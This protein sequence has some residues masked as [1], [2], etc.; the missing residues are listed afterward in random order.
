MSQNRHLSALKIRTTFFDFGTEHAQRLC[1]GTI[2]YSSAMFRANRTELT[3][4]VTA[5]RTSN[6]SATG[7]RTSSVEETLDANPPQ[8]ADAIAATNNSARRYAAAALA[9]ATAVA[10]TKTVAQTAAPQPLAATDPMKQA[11][12]DA[13]TGSYANVLTNNL[14]R[15]TPFN[16]APVGIQWTNLSNGRSDGA[17]RAV[18]NVDKQGGQEL[19]TLL[20]GTLVDSPFSTFGTQ[21]KDQ[22]IRMPNGQMIDA[23]VLANSLNAARTAKDPFSATQNVLDTYRAEAASYNL[24]NSTNAIDSVTKGNLKVVNANTLPT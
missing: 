7:R 18:G 11:W 20:G 9:D 8:R 22:Y 17:T 4:R 16:I 5:S 13:N 12:L 10:S 24:N 1:M 14:N 6:N 3:N 23:S 2:S 15:S 21:Q 19:A